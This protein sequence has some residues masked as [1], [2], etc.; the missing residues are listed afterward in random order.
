MIQHTWQPTRRHR[1]KPSSLPGSRAP[2]E[3]CERCRWL[4]ALPA[5]EP[6]EEGRRRRPIAEMPTRHSSGAGPHGQ[7]YG[8]R[9]HPIFFR[10]LAVARRQGFVRT[11]R[12]APVPAES[13]RTHLTGRP[14]HVLTP[15][16][17]RRPRGCPSHRSTHPSQTTKRPYHLR[18]PR[19]SPSPSRSPALFHHLIGLT[20][21]LTL[22]TR[23]APLQLASSAS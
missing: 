19:T 18:A 4:R 22:V 6:S 8:D 23:I 2:A 21:Q 16:L 10:H 9:P 11:L 7:R 15:C 13:A 3:R 5:Q 1:E 20:A 14:R 12:P 17:F